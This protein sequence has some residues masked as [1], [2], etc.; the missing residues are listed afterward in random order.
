MIETDASQDCLKVVLMQ[1]RM[2][3]A[4]M[5]KKLSVKNQSLFTYEK[6][7]LALFTTCE[8]I[9]TTNQIS[10]KYLLE[11]RVNTP[12]QHKGLSKFISLNYKIEYKKGLQ[13]KTAD[14]LS[15]QERHSEKEEEVKNG[16]S[17]TQEVEGGV[18]EWQNGKNG[19]QEVEG[20]IEGEAKIQ[21]VSELLPKW[22]GEVKVAMRMTNGFMN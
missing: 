4:F 22:I 18:K 8:F 21:V 3:N 10:L 1:G 13:K 2:P 17:D 16:N 6:E 7:L 9:I 12:M 19:T 14:A 5:S 11:Q 20:H 15:R